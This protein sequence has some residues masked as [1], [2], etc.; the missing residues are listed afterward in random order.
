LRA[1]AQSGSI[2]R[3]NAAMSRVE[4]ATNRHPGE[5]AWRRHD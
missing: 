2:K 3:A 1:A 4:I 5:A